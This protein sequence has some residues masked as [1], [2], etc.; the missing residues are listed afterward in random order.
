MSCGGTRWGKSFMEAPNIGIAVA[1]PR[2]YEA[3]AW[4]S[5]AARKAQYEIIE[6]QIVRLR[7]KSTATQC[8]YVS[9]RRL[10][11]LSQNSYLPAFLLS[12][13]DSGWSACG[14][15]VGD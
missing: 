1:S 14:R 2:S 3:Y 4:P 5:L 13:W 11:E 10:P 6:Q 15:S 7:R 8:Y 9:R 12:T